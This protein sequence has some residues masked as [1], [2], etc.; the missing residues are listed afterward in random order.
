MLRRKQ[1][2]VENR[3]HR[4]RTVS[5]FLAVALFCC[6]TGASAAPT[7]N[8]WYGLNQ[9]FGQIGNP[10]NQINIFGNVFDGNGISSLT[11]TLNGASPITLSRGPDTR[12]LLSAGDFNIDINTSSLIS[13]ANTVV[14]S[15][16]NTL[17]QL[18]TANVTVTYA[19]NQQWPITYA[20]DWSA[21]STAQN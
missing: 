16:T 15:A 8:V 3:S 1:E 12:R 11:Y 21:G 13:G 9:S 19:T 14:I 4:N 7:I 6:L 20:I 2:I 10:Q 5:V 17:S 18:T